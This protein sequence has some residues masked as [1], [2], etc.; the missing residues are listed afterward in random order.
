MPCQ[1][2][3]TAQL[4]GKYKADTENYVSCMPLAYSNILL[5]SNPNETMISKL[6]VTT[7]EFQWMQECHCHGDI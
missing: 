6:L 2:T 3:L 4:L 1:P 5:L 7:P